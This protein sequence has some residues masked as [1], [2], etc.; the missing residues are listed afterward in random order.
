MRQTIFKN[1][2][3]LN[4]FTKQTLKK[5]LSSSK[6]EEISNQGYLYKQGEKFTHFYLIIY[7]E[8]EQLWHDE[9]VIQQIQQN[10]KIINEQM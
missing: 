8:F 5:L 7:G 1:F 4:N 9:N 6:L 2:S 10:K 3:Y